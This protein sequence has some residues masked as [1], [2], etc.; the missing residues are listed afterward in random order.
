MRVKGVK[1]ESWLFIGKLAISIAMLWFL[2]SAAQIKL[3]L[4]LNLLQRP[5]LFFSVIGIFLSMVVI[6]TWRWQMLNYAQGIHFGYF[7]TLVATYLAAAFNNVLPGAIGGD[8]IRLFYIF[9]KVPQKKSNAFLAV[10]FDR[11]IGFIAV[12]VL[13]CGVAIFHLKFLNQQPK[14]FYLLFT[15]IVFC[16]S[17]LL[18]LAAC[19]LLPQRLGLNTWLQ[20]RFP[21]QSWARMINSFFDAINTCQITKR[22]AAKCFSISVGIQL[23]IVSAVLI[24]AKMMDLPSVSFSDYVIAIGVTQIVNLIPITPGG[25]GIGEMAFAN[26]LS[27]LNPDKVAAYATILFAYRILS[28]LTYLPGVIWY[29]FKFVLFKKKKQLQEEIIKEPEGLLL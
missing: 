4:F 6:G 5:I 28:A 8:V 9:K 20:Q 21:H 7:K 2:I 16:V 23:L 19:M 12:F 1:K 17:A 15:C 26:I 22:V 25:I 18:V 10:F 11:V 14:L 29:I 24:I 3:E 27:I 13:I